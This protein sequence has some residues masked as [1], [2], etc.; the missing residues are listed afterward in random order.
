MPKIRVFQIAKELNISHTDILFFLKSKKIEVSSHMAPVEENIHKMIMDEFANDKVQFFRQIL[1]ACLEEHQ[2]QIEDL[3][4]QIEELKEKKIKLVDT[5]D[6]ELEQMYSSTLG[7]IS[8]HSLIQGRVV[9]MNERDVLIDIGFKSEGIIDRS[10]FNENEL[11]AIGDHVE[12]Y[13]EFIEDASGRAILS[14]EK[15]DY[16]RREKELGQ[17]SDPEIKEYLEP[18]LFRDIRETANIENKVC[19]ENKSESTEVQTNSAQSKEPIDD[20]KLKSSTEEIEYYEDGTIKMITYFEKSN[21]NKEKIKKVDFFQNGEKKYERFFS[22]NELNGPGI[23]YYEE[24]G[25]KREYNHENGVM[26]G[27]DTTYYKNG[28]KSM[29]GNRKHP[30]NR[31]VG[32]WYG[33]YENGEKMYESDSDDSSNGTYTEWYQNGQ[34]K[35]EGKIKWGMKEKQIVYR[36]DGSTITDSDEILKNDMNKTLK[37]MEDDYNKNSENLGLDTTFDDFLDII[38]G[39]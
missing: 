26:D 6:N 4:K 8:E 30:M 22:N 9:G 15:A 39:K 21:G 20:S 1:D 2:T 27:L 34:K 12:V 11:P 36:E 10:E 13:L 24:G 3:Q 25:K 31:M 18:E 14:K 38:R 16:F 17:L 7:D 37:N 19:D 5:V 28:Q 33:W 23:E 29:E 35:E 32:K